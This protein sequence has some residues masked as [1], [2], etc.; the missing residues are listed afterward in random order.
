[1]RFITSL[2]KE[3]VI[4]FFGKIK[5]R[6]MEILIKKCVNYTNNLRVIK[7]KNEC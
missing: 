3:I 2:N 5:M 6:G 4:R 7:K 1:M